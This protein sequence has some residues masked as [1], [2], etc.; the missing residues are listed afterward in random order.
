M[1]DLDRLDLAQVS[2]KW[3]ALVEVVVQI[4]F[5]QQEKYFMTI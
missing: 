4:Q 5:P 1:E 2:N 3:L